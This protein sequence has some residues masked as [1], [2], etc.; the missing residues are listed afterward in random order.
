MVYDKDLHYVKQ[1]DITIDNTPL[2]KIIGVAKNLL[3]TY[4]KYYKFSDDGTKLEIV[5]PEVKH[6]Y[7]TLLISENLKCYFYE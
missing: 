3:I 5:A 4:K 7:K 2:R 6:L 1:I